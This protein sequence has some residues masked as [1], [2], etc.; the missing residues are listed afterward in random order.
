MDE[1][2]KEAIS[3]IASKKSQIAMVSSKK[4]DGPAVAIEKA[5]IVIKVEAKK[6]KENILKVFSIRGDN[7]PEAPK[8]QLLDAVAEVPAKTAGIGLDIAKLALLLPLLMS[9]KVKSLIGGFFEGFMKQLGVAQPIVDAVV[10]AAKNL[11]VIVA[12]YFG[13]KLFK[14][15]LGVF[16]S[17]KNLARV[18]GLVGAA[19]SEQGDLNNLDRKKNDIERES[20]KKEK[21]TVRD[22]HSD[23]KDEKASAAK[24]NQKEVDALKAEKKA[25]EAEKKTA[26]KAA[27][28]IKKTGAAASGELRGIKKLNFG[29]KLV[30]FI[31]TLAKRVLPKILAAIPVVGTIAMVG[32]AIY[33]IIDTVS[34]FFTLQEI[35]TAFLSPLKTAKDILGA[36]ADEITGKSDETPAA[37]PETSVQ[38]NIIIQN[39]AYSIYIKKQT[40]DDVPPIYKEPVKRVLASPPAHW[41]KDAAQKP[42]VTEPGRKSTSV[43]VPTVAM[44]ES[45]PSISASAPEEATSLSTGVQGEESLGTGALETTTPP[46]ATSTGTLAAAS[47]EPKSESTAIMRRSEDVLHNDE[48]SNKASVFITNIDNSKNTTVARNSKESNSSYPPTFYL[49]MA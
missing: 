27:E 44:L 39:Y 3:N 24:K 45:S 46:A 25:L 29:K 18:A 40:I 10:F 41:M 9:D 34:S 37:V 30:R 14:S 23:L 11:G 12:G 16:E 33:D 42:Q 8:P 19:A 20:V 47:I 7:I 2:K 35:K 5:S 6:F 1:G 22:R 31:P 36:V 43:S 26:E 49:L 38:S 28:R 32:Y 13:I 4:D 21:K 48:M 15:V 17:I